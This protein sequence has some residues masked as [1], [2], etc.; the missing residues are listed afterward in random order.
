MLLVMLETLRRSEFGLK[1]KSNN[2]MGGSFPDSEQTATSRKL[3]KFYTVAN[4]IPSNI[5]ADYVMALLQDNKKSG[6]F[7]VLFE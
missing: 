7:L 1:L 3:N 4:F 2:V 5:L 6:V